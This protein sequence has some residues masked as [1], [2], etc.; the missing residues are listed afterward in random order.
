M[1]NPMPPMKPG[2]LFGAAG[3]GLNALGGLPFPLPLPSTTPKL[4]Y[5][6]VSTAE[7]TSFSPTK[8]KHMVSNYY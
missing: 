6:P 4:P 2:G 7:R 8:P 1:F 5:P 3:M